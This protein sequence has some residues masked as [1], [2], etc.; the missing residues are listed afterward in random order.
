MAIELPIQW[1]H[2]Q[3]VY[4]FATIT[5]LLPFLLSVGIFLRSW[6][7]YASSAYASEV[8]DRPRT[9]TSSTTS[10]SNSEVIEVARFFQGYS[11]GPY[12]YPYGYPYG[13]NQYQDRNAY[14]YNDDYYN[15]NYNDDNYANWS[16]E[17]QDLRWPQ[18]VYYTRWS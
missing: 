13:Y 17:S 4:D 18:G 11:P 5:Q 1:N 12:Y 10:S 9:R 14:N 16:R 3:G 2:V 8:E 7:V 15:Y 6:A